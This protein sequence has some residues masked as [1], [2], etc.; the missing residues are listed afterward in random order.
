MVRMV[1]LVAQ[2]SDLVR[3]LITVIRKS[4][5]RKNLD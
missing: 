1:E 5:I 2:P 4:I 3:Q